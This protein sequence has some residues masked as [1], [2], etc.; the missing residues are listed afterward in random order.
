MPCEISCSAR[1]LQ[2]GF[3][4]TVL[5]V[6]RALAFPVVTRPQKRVA[7]WE[8]LNKSSSGGSKKA[9][10]PVVCEAEPAEMEGGSG[11]V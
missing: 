5:A 4:N 6:R 7:K 1:E 2:R 10:V 9:R 11:R 3:S 8:A